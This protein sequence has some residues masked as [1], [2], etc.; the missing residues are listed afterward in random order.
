MKTHAP[1]G[2]TRCGKVRVCEAGPPSVYNAPTQAQPIKA[3]SSSL[4]NSVTIMS[5]SFIGETLDR[6]YPGW[7]ELPFLFA[8]LDFEIAN[9]SL[10]CQHHVFFA[11][12]T[13]FSSECLYMLMSLEW[14]DL[15]RVKRSLMARV[16][17][18]PKV[19]WARVATPMWCA[20]FP[21]LVWHRLLKKSK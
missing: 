8:W 2:G 13:I 20:P 19:E 4:Y 9:Q 21:S 14:N 16:V 6:F 12:L 1:G 18:I 15:H 5:L 7:P 3:S 11:I 10:W 17:V